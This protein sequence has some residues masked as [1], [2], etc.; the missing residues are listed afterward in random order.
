MSS[1][2]QEHR[3]SYKAGI[4]RTPSDFLCQD[5]ELAECINLTTDNE[6]L[7]PIVQP[8]EYISG[9]TS[10]SAVTILYIHKFN[11]ESRYIGYNSQNKIVWCIKS[12]TT[13]IN[14]TLL[15][16]DYDSSVKVTSIGKTLIISSDNFPIKTFIWKNNNTYSSAISNLP[17]IKLSADLERR[18]VIE[19]TAKMGDIFGQTHFNTN[20]H[21]ENQSDYNELVTGLYLECVNDIKK[22]KCFTKPFFVCAA[23]ELF[24]GTFTMMSQPILMPVT[25]TNNV[26]G[27]ITLT[28]DGND[29]YLYARAMKIYAAY[30]ELSIKQ[31]TDYSAYSDIVKDVVIFVTDGI[32]FYDVTG[33]QAITYIAEGGILIDGIIDHHIT[34]TTRPAY[35]STGDYQAYFNILNKRDTTSIN[36]DVKGASLFYKIC[37]IGLSPKDMATVTGRID[38]NT[39]VNLTTQDRLDNVDYYSNN[40]LYAHVLFSYNSRLNI[41]GAKRSIFQGFSYFMPY[42]TTIDGCTIKVEIETDSGNKVAVYNNA[43]LPDKTGYWFYYPDSRAKK[44]EILN[45]SETVIFAHAL[46]E[47]S[48]LNGAYCFLGFPHNNT[49]T[50]TSDSTTITATDQS[51]EK[52]PN[53]I[54]TSSVNNPWVFEAEGYNKVGTGE[55]Y[56]LSTTTMALNQDQF[57]VTDLLVFSEIGVWGMKV[58]KTGLFQSVHSI[59]RDVLIYPHNLIQTD[60]AVFFVSKKGLMVVSEDGVR[61]LSERIN[62]VPFNTSALTGLAT[63]TDWA[64]IVTAGQTND[65]F[66]KYIRSASCVIAYDYIESRLIIT[67]PTYNFSYIYN[68][69]DGTIAKTILPGVVT[70]VVNNY[71]DYLMQAGNKLYSFYEKTREEEVASRQTAFLLTRPMKLSG[72]VSK[73]SLRQ[74]KNV[75]VWDEGTTQIPL[76]CVKTKIYLSDDMKSWHEDTSRFGA[77][78]KYYRLALFIKMLPSER[79]SGTIITTQPRR[80]NNFR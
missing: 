28:P 10:D 12:S 29:N 50:P 31:E 52:L 69:A 21:E 19:H 51:P 72:P 20:I 5:G 38:S 35:P 25:V 26:Y 75:G 22:K 7:K 16:V 80:T 42:G 67:N 32:D 37:S 76:S 34:S 33:D 57:G 64:S 59:T 36:Q 27:T 2:D 54:I 3:I 13:L 58:D 61:F 65:A 39:L 8:A 17:P 24:D 62:G 66:Q 73:D 46:E 49:D 41:A 44:V 55:I 79:L 15:G 68:I 74:L 53:Y 56:A 14:V 45:S 23:L 40:L 9:I 18:G 60:G 4:T 11:S 78:A 6:E 63:G 43:S 48:G 71:P 70:N 77:A 47:H 30:A 1:L